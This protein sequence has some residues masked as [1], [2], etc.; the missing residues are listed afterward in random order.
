MKHFLF[1]LSFFLVSFFCF[2]QSNTKTSKLKV[3]DKVNESFIYYKDSLSSD[4][5]DVPIVESGKIKPAMIL[6]Y[7]FGELNGKKDNYDSL[8][9]VVQQVY[10]LNRYFGPYRKP[11]RLTCYLFVKEVNAQALALKAQINAWSKAIG[12]SMV[13]TER[14]GFNFNRPWQIL[15]IK[16]SDV[17]PGSVLALNKLSVI[18]ADGVL[19]YSSSIEQFRFNGKRGSVKGKIL[20]EKQAKKLP[21]PNVMVG[22]LNLRTGKEE[23]DSSMSDMYGDFE[24]SVQD[25]SAEYTIIVKSKSPE[26][27][28]VILATQSGQEIAR[29]KKTS[30]GFEYKLIPTD[31]VLLTEKENEDITML[32]NKFGGSKETDLKVSENI[33]YALGQYKIEDLESKKILDK[34]VKILK[35]NPKVTLQVISHTDAQGDDSFNMN[36][37]EKR[38]ASV[39]TYFIQKGIDKKRLT[40]IGKGETEIR[41]RCMNEVDCSDREH[42][43]NRRTEFKFTKG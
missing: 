11:S 28:N 2:S 16:D 20:T 40:S 4:K 31:I 23:A 3:G 17:K 15:F 26:L 21:V 9:K 37:S 29:L 10:R 42:E 7:R 25:E 1:C 8:Y 6:F 14:A 22:L 36:L 43:Y 13:K 33:L 27:D 5:F 12:D 24:I 38:S 30:R 19:M 41:N 34:V 32:F 18:A 39:I 35:E